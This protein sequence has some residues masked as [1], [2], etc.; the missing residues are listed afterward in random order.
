[1]YK[2]QLLRHVT[3][4]FVEDPV[5]LLRVARFAARLGQWGFHVAHGTNALLKRMAASEDLRALRPERV[6]Q[7]MRRA[8]AEPQPWRFFAVLHRCGALATLIPE[9]AAVLG[10]HETHAE[11]LQPAALAALQRA[12]AADA[13]PAARFA[14][15]FHGAVPQPAGVGPFCRRLR[16]ERE[17]TELLGLLD[18]ALPELCRLDGASAAELVTF[19]DRYRGFQNARRFADL[20]VAAEAVDPALAPLCA[21]LRLA[22]DAA[23]AVSAA[24]L[25]EA[26]LAGPALGAELLRR[27]QM[28]AAALE[29]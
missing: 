23:A 18:Q 17:E 27:R 29:T 6:W 15:L 28:A 22:R 10:P 11:E 9:L 16:A 7:E 1:V 2:R 5:R 12:A 14:A 13:G 25:R 26:G 21:R 20:L 3:P 19:A 4:A 24:P 8:L